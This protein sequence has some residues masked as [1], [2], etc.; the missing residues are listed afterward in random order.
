[1]EI[2]L[3]TERNFESE[4]LFQASRSGGAGGQNVNKVN[5]MVELRFSIQNSAIL[6]NEEKIVL[7]EKLAT[8]ISADGFIIIVSQEER[9]QWRNKQKCIEKFYNIIGKALRPTKKRKPTKPTEESKEKRISTKRK[10]S[11]KKELRRKLL[12]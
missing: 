6:T 8:K 10:I 4:F 9:S 3:L 12:E 5:T 1:M 7:A 2:N 11:E